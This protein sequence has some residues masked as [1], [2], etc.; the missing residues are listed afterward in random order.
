[1]HVAV[2]IV[3]FRNAQDIAHC[4]EALA[5]SAWTDFEV[6]L[7]ENG[8]PGAFEAVCAAT[9]AAL[10]GGQL[11]RRCLAPGNLGFAGGVNYGIEA[12]RN[13]DAWW[14]LNPDT[15]PRPAAL[16]ALV[17]RLQTGDCDAVGGVLYDGEGRVQAYGG[18]WQPW[19]ARAVSIGKGERLGDGPPPGEIER[20]QSYLLGASML[21]SRRFVEVAGLMREDYFLYCEE[22]EWC[23]RATRRGL[24]LGFAPGALVLHHQGA[25]TGAGDAMRRQPRTPVFFGERNKI[26]LTRDLYPRRLPLTV[27]LGLAVVFARYARRGAWRQVGY[28]LGGWWAGVRDRRGR[29]D[30]IPG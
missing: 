2:V 30:W 13:A 20:T 6:V 15:E 27:I 17:A 11:V 29:P 12:S 25:T 28:A 5:A 7:V 19:L 1:L 26:L 21:V 3:G 24:R 9:A 18:R 22:S 23:L 14:I 8:G 16:A 10:P 4:L